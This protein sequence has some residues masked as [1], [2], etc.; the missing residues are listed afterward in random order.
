MSNMAKIDIFC[1][2]E[3]NY[4]LEMTPVTL[5]GPYI[6]LKT[7]EKVFCDPYLVSEGH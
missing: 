5:A 6:N 3:Q 2:F 4:P 7:I 1:D